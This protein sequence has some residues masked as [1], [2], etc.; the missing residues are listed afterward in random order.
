[1]F[2]LLRSLALGTVGFTRTI[3]RTSFAFCIAI[4]RDSLRRKLEFKVAC[5]R[6]DV[7]WRGVF[8]LD[9]FDEIELVLL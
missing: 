9:L 2:H 5:P 8:V 3:L 6:P 4:S 7:V 1:M